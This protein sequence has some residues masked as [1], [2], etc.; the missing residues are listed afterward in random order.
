MRDYEGLIPGGTTQQVKDKDVLDILMKQSSTYFTPGS[1]YRY[2]NAGYATLAVIVNRVSGI[3][4]AE[5]L[6]NNIFT[7]LGMK[8]TVAYEK[9]I[10]EVSDRAYGYTQRNGKFQ[11]TDQSLT[12]AVLGDGGVYT[13]VDEILIWDQALYTDILVSQNLMDMAFTPGKLNSGASTRYGFGWVLDTYK[14]IKRISHTGSTIGFRSAIQRFPEKELT[15][16]V[17]VN[18]AGAQPWETARRVAD[19]FWNQ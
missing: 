2:S 12:S 1:Q 15:V 8:N 10:S 13:S 18:R 6:E 16:V 11:R 3:S 19:L 14:G 5:F 17:L 7:P 9:G 4:F